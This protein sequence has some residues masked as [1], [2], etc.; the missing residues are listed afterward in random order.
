MAVV[1]AKC[2]HCLGVAQLRVIGHWP[3]QGPMKGNEVSLGAACP[4]CSM[5]VAILARYEG[6][7]HEWGHWMNNLATSTG[8]IANHKL[9]YLRH[10]PAPPMPACPAHL[11]PNV[12]KAFLSAEHNFPQKGQEEA[13]GMMYRR[14]LELGLTAKYPERNGTLAQ[15]I[16][17]LVDDRVLTEDI[18]RWANDVRLIGNE[19]AHGDEVTRDELIAIRGFADAVLRYVWTLPAQ[20]AQ[21]HA[22]K[23]TASAPI[24]T[25]KPE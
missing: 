12:E 19:A 8:P 22:D 7:A 1:M 3:H 24:V 25:K 6:A 9:T 15:T 2:P 10:W 4:G 13:S 21:R 18:G 16:R 17:G 11:P 5:P 23:P 20:V 14:A